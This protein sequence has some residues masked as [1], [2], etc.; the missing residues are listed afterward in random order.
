MV[1]KDNKGGRQTTIPTEKKNRRKFQVCN[2]YLLEFDQLARVLH[3]LLEN[4]DAKKISRKVI[5]E[6]TGLADRQLESLVSIGSAMGLI[7][8]GVQTLSAVGLLIAEN[9]I[10]IEKRG[11]LEWCH[12]AGAGS[13][14]NLIWYEIFN[15]LLQ[16]KGTITQSSLT[17]SLRSRLEGQYAERTIKKS[18]REEVHFVVDAYLERNLKKLELL[19][20]T[21]DERLYIRRYTNFAPLV[22]SAMLYDF[23]ADKG[24]QLFQ[25][26]ELAFMPGSPALL[27][28]LDTATLR[29]Q[30]EGLHERGWLRYET[31]HSL[32]QV[33]LKPSFSAL[34]FLTAHFE[35][36]EPCETA[37]SPAG[38]LF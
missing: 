25:V 28:G 8:P 10:F 37:A 12:Y 33:R 26:D 1:Q 9:D 11:S 21:S 20:Q 24:T 5:Q 17:E 35:A 38:E 30:V 13:Y 29:Q 31:T 18:L 15:S 22:F 6:S 36:R 2:G 7:R 19:R 23:G 34:E 3:F 14:R 32:D 27:F 16:E 4:R